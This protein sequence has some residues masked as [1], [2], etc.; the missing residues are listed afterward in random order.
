MKG[1]ALSTETMVVII[2]CVLILAVVIYFVLFFRNDETVNWQATYELACLKL[3]LDC[4]ADL[5]TIE[6]ETA[7]GRYSLNTICSNLQ[8]DDTTC[9]DNCGCKV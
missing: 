5:N 1:I 6:V 7:A 2:I 8:L 3:I 9:R 4:D